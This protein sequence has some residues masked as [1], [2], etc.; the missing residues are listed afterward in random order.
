MNVF[1]FLGQ[2]LLKLDPPRSK[3]SFEL[4]HSKLMDALGVVDADDKLLAIKCLVAVEFYIFFINSTTKRNL[5]HHAEAARLQCSLYLME[6][7]KIEEV[8]A[9]CVVFA[10]SENSF[11]ENFLSRFKGKARRRLL[12]STALVFKCVYDYFRISKTINYSVKTNVTKLLDEHQS[13]LPSDKSSL[14]QLD[15]LT[16][17][18]PFRNTQIICGINPSIEYFRAVAS[19][20][21]NAFALVPLSVGNKLSNVLVIK[22]IETALPKKLE[23]GDYDSNRAMDNCAEI[24]FPYQESY[25]DLNG[26]EISCLDII[27]DHL[28]LLG[29]QESFVYV[30]D[31]HS[32]NKIGILRSKAS[33]IC[34]SEKY[35]FVIYERQIKVFN[36]EDVV[37]ILAEDIDNVVDHCE[38]ITFPGEVIQA[39]CSNHDYLALCIAREDGLGT[40]EVWKYCGSGYDLHFINTLYRDIKFYLPF[41][42]TQVPVEEQLF[43]DEIDSRILMRKRS[44]VEIPCGIFF[45]DSKLYVTGYTKGNVNALDIWNM[46]EIELGTEFDVESVIDFRQTSTSLSL[47]K[48]NKRPFVFIGGEKLTMVNIL[49]GKVVYDEFISVPRLEIKKD[50]S[51]ALCLNDRRPEKDVGRI[52]NIWIHDKNLYLLYCEKNYISYIIQ[53]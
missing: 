36:Y 9:A 37:E 24:S 15:P 45:D 17:L 44:S 2:L 32:L 35:I 50:L 23:H 25:L 39:A 40:L 47:A 42:F 8:T 12:K 14:F 27:D 30:Y 46:D 31:V 28:L 5:I 19:T 38:T 13:L 43:Y 20:N 51:L 7:S 49:S 18:V 11:R 1:S 52:E 33:T 53:Y 48:F 10:R 34:S 21:S 6:L 26:A 3:K 4:A 16:D 41:Q 22:L 29:G